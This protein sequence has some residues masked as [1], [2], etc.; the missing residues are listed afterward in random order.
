M[1]GVRGFE[2]P[3]PASR[4]LSAACKLLS[5]LAAAR[6]TGEQDA[7]LRTT[8]HDQSR[9]IH[10]PCKVLTASCMP[11]QPSESGGARRHPA[12]RFYHNYA[13]CM[14]QSERRSR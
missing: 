12:E 13:R 1:V 14:L 8:T 7:L 10:E 11:C 6:Q 4:R 9:I 5:L 3:A 2:P